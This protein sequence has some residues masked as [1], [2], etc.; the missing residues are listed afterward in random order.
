MSTVKRK[1]TKKSD[2]WDKIKSP[3]TTKEVNKAGNTDQT[4]SRLKLGEIGTTALNTI[5]VYA[6]WIRPYE[7]SWPRCLDTYSLMA[8]DAD[9]ATALTANYLFVERAFDEF[10]VKYKKGNRKSE[11]AAKFVEWCLK[12]MDSQTLRQVARE[13]LTY[14]VYGFSVLEK[15]FTKVTSGEY[16][17]NYKIKKLAS[18]PQSTL[19]RNKPFRYSDDGRDVLGVYQVIPNKSTFTTDTD[20]S[21][22]GEIYIPRNKFLLFG[23]Q[24][25]DSNPTGVSPLS[26]IYITWKEKTLISE[27]E[28]VGVGKDLGGTPV[29]KVPTDILNRAA[30]DPNSDEAM[31][32]E[33]LKANLA[34]LHAGEQAYMIIPSDLHDQSTTPQYEI[35]FLGIDGSGK[36]FDT[37]ELKQQRKK[38][39]YDSFGA[40]F[41]IMGNSE[42]GSYSLSDN[43]QTLHSQFI[44]HDVKGISEVLNKDLIPQLLALN[45]IYLTDEEMPV[46]EPGDVGDPDIE[47]NSKMIQRVV[48]VGAIPLNVETMNEMLE[49]CGFKYRIPDDIVSDPEKAAEFIANNVPASTSRSGDGLAAGGLNGTST[50]ASSTD[51]SIMNNENA[52]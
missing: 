37:T 27:Y 23:E 24:I 11:K 18:R 22:V 34:N 32:I 6:N 51:T 29:L 47:G 45:G 30:V 52:A 9:V 26:S 39:I 19:R 48:A 44:E 41:L 25:T 1:Y 46:F 10:E 38:E 7:I 8:N 5:N 14:K 33:T 12:N 13:A 36:Q 3:Q 43:K 4:T 2:Y 50:T 35:K 16:A 21:L 42:T 17:G 15:V 40:G 49:M 28:V 20:V 31:S